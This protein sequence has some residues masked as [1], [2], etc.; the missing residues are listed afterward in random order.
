MENVVIERTLSKNGHPIIKMNGLYIHSKYDPVQEAKRIVEKEYESG[1]L[2]ILFGYGLG[3]VADELMKKNN[4]E[5]L[6]II[7]P[8]Y[9]EL[10]PN[11]SHH[12]VEVLT[13]YSRIEL[14]YAIASST[15]NY[16]KKIKVVVTPNYDRLLPEE[17]LFLL[18]VVKDVQNVNQVH[19]NTTN[20]YAEAWEKNYISNL[21]HLLNEPTIYELKKQYDC[22]VVLASGGPSLTKQLPLLK[23]YR[24]K[25]ILISAGSTVNSLIQAGIEPDY[26]VTVD[27]GIENYAHF[28]KVS[29]QQA[30]LMYAVSSYFQIQ[31]EFPNRKYGFLSDSDIEF[32]RHIQKLFS[33]DAPLVTGGTS[34]ANFAFTIA[35]L[36]TS[37][38]IAL[39]GQDLAFTNNQTHAANNKF[40]KELDAQFLKNRHVFEVDGYYG[41]KVLTDYAFYSMKQSF[42]ELNRILKVESSIWNCTEGGVKIEGIRQMAFQSFCEKYVAQYQNVEKVKIDEQ[43][44]EKTD[45]FIEIMEQELKHYDQVIRDITSAL[46]MVLG[47]KGKGYFKSS[48]LNK[49]N[50]FDENIKMVMA[51]VSMNKIL[52]P[53]I[54]D[55]MNNYQPIVNENAEQTF[56]RVYNQNKEMYSRLL[57]AVEK[58]K[59]YT[60]E[61]I[62]K[63]KSRCQNG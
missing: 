8:L 41:D 16:S 36:I 18:N 50:K 6:L 1:Y 19:V 57:E 11:H 30:E 55:M 42:E 20:R 48:T 39:I 14:N 45:R 3:Y 31:D 54:I 62:V 26:I 60:H 2:M 27:G 22:P 23:Q 17:Y 47:S 46:Q 59:R 58:S 29:F 25:L 49:M 9:E 7:D 13:D 35:T 61:V 34:V 63:V 15:K 32:Q 53:I 10:H 51:K 33:I 24:N 28:S 56:Q 4:G 44:E 43:V 40:A 12:E 37:G 5:N 52:E 38:P 21:Y